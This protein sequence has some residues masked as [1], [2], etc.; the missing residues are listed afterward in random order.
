MSDLYVRAAAITIALGISPVAVLAELDTSGMPD[1]T[2]AGHSKASTWVSA[3]ADG[4]YIATCGED[5][6]TRIWKREDLSLYKTISSPAFKKE[7]AEFSPDGAIMAETGTDGKVNVRKVG[8]SAGF[9]LA[10]TLPAGNTDV[11]SLTMSQDGTLLAA[12]AGAVVKLWRTKDYFL[13]DLRDSAGQVRAIAMSG[14]GRY[15]A[16]TTESWAVYLYDLET[17][18]LITEFTDE[19][20]PYTA[21]AMSQDGTYLVYGGYTGKVTFRELATGNIVRT[22]PAHS[23]FLTSCAVS[24]DNKYF[25]T[26]S[27]AG[28]IKLWRMSSFGVVAT[29]TGQSGGVLHVSFSPDGEFLLSAGGD[30]TYEMWDLGRLLGRRRPSARAHS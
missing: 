7:A 9:G 27:I 2:V 24:P 10:K 6:T 21:V 26:S 30:G 8:L 4:R 22:I 15:L 14:D 3:G 11:S 13:R 25:A 1:F 23:R 17:K 16:S 5:G 18:R 20:Y 19:D 28:D 29:L 12:G